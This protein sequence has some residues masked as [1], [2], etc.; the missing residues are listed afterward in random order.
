MQGVLSASLE[1]L[2]AAGATKRQATAIWSRY[3]ARPDDHVVPTPSS[4]DRAE[5]QAVDN[6]FEDAVLGTTDSQPP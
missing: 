2:M 6:A 1:E 5:R 4:N 3:H